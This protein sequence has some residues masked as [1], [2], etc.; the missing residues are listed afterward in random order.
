MDRIECMRAFIEAVR[1]ESFAG[2]ART[3]DVPR[4]KISKLVKDLEQSLGVKLL[5][6]TTRSLHLT[7]AGTAFY[8][9]A[10]EVLAALEEAEERARGTLGIRGIVRCNV[11]VSFGM[12]V[13]AGLVPRF[14]ERY[15]DIEL[16]VSL[17]DHLIDP[18]RGGFDVTI[19]I[20][21]LA[22]SSFAARRIMPAPR[23]LVASPA[24]LAQRGTPQ[25]PDDLADHAFINYGCL[26]SGSTSQL[27]RGKEGR[28]VRTRG[29]GM[30]DNGDFLVQMADAGLGIALVPDFIAADAITAGTL[31]R[32]LEDWSAPPIAVHA[33]FQQTRSMSLRLR[34]FIDFLVEE[35]GEELGEDCD[36]P[37]ISS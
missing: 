25:A 32:V 15:P 2:A 31:V 5:M 22:D 16:Q 1:A 3:L 10:Q 28:R 9:D 13:L 8:E 11:P 7:E 20:A 36:D 24:Y 30:A 26:Q 27:T 4:S 37:A 17:T 35:L 14:L 29:P 34:R 6:R 12:R 18:V 33:L 21:D 19:R 23:S